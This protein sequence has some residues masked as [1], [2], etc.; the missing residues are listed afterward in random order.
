MFRFGTE[1]FLAV[2]QVD[3]DLKGVPA[4][5]IENCRSSDQVRPVFLTRR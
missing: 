5:A 3:S 2:G 1:A 4:N